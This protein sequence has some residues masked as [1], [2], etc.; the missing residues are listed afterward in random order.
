MIRAP[1]YRIR[2]DVVHRSLGD[3]HYLL[4]AD[5]AFHSVSDPV[6]AFVLDLLE[7][8]PGLSLDAIVRAVRL[9]FE[10][11]EADVESDVRTFLESLVV[12]EVLE[13]FAGE[14]ET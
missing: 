5:G 6:G 12:R 3:E 2:T 4:S 11:G 9:A 13:R 10:V 8:P 7:D 1:I 14:G